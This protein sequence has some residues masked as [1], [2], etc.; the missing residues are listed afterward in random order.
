M[1]ADRSWL[2]TTCKSVASRLTS[3]PT[4]RDTADFERGVAFG[5]AARDFLDELSFEVVDFLLMRALRGA[6]VFGTTLPESSRRLV[7]ISRP[8]TTG[9]PRVRARS[10]NHPLARSGLRARNQT[11]GCVVL[12]ALVQRER[13]RSS[14]CERPGSAIGRDLRSRL[15]R[16]NENEWRRRSR[17]ATA[18]RRSERGVSGAVA[19]LRTERRSSRDGARTGVELGGAFDCTERVRTSSRRS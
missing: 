14:S 16:R 10:P 8:R 18:T 5:F 1:A 6:R 11:S 7:P 13:A 4:S 15:R 17:C 3:R 19:Q 12:V 9:R 2:A